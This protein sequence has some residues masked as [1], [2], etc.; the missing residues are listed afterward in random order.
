MSTEPPSPKA[1]L[2]LE[3]ILTTAAGRWANGVCLGCGQRAAPTRVPPQGKLPPLILCPPCV[4]RLE[5]GVARLFS[6]WVLAP[7]RRRVES[8][9]R[10]HQERD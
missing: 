2:S 4:E 9:R 10:A 3:T 6:S 1:P 5:P 8:V 7:L